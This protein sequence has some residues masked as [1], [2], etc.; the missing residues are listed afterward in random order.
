M[1]RVVQAIDGDLPVMVISAGLNTHSE[2]ED[3]ILYHSLG[4]SITLRGC[5]VQTDDGGLGQR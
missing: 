5:E 3:Q 1:A 2:T 4:K